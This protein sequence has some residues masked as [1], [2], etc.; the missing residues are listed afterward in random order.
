VDG[1]LLRGAQLPEGRQVHLL[2]AYDTDTGIVLAQVAIA[3]KSNEIPAFTPLLDQLQAELGSLDGTIVVADALHA[4][5][6]HAH[7]VHARDLVAQRRR[8]CPRNHPRTAVSLHATSSPAGRLSCPAPSR[9]ST[10]L[11]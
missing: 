6:G 5:V 2:S 3:A 7:A 8:G 4:Q 1:K 10:S 11:W 9:R